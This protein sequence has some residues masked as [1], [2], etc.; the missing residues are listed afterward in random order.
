MRKIIDPFTVNLPSIDL[1][2]LDRTLAKIE[3]EDFI[4]DSVKLKYKQ[5]LI[6]H[7]IGEGILRQEVFKILKTNKN[8]ESYKIN[9]INV[10]CTIVN[11]KID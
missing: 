8:V 2:G 9:G 1:H 4:R 10:G 5:I 7:G 3:V 11:L 6:I